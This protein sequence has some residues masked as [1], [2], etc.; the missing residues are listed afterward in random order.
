MDDDP[1][2]LGFDRNP[3]PA[4]VARRH[5][6]R[7]D[8]LSQERSAVDLLPRVGEAEDVGRV[9][10]GAMPQVQRAHLPGLDENDREGR[11]GPP[12]EL[13]HLRAEGRDRAAQPPIRRAPV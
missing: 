2:Q 3:S 10:S 7:N 8:H 12:D 6:R 9:V 13:E 1:T 11:L 4:R 5:L